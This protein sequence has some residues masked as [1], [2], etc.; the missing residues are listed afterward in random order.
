[1]PYSPSGRLGNAAIV[2]AVVAALAA[3]VWSY[4]RLWGYM[5]D[6]GFISLRYAQHLSQGL[7]LVYNAGD[8][9]GGYTN[10]LW[11]VLLS[12]PFLLKLPLV[13]FVKITNALLAIIAAWATWRLGR[14]SASELGRER[15][16]SWLPALLFL[17]TPA[18]IISAAEGLETM[19]FTA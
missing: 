10:F 19:L 7:G 18:V 11:T 5:V 9:V 13:P 6:D 4:L 3:F 1:M 17:V 12:V 15:R 8:R 2:T 14:A 16:W